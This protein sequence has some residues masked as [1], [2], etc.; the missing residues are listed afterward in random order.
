MLLPDVPE[1]ELPVDPEPLDPEEPFSLLFAVVSDE[2]SF[3][4]VESL[5]LLSPSPDFFEPLLLA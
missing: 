2:P 1:P 4:V 3:L 5:A